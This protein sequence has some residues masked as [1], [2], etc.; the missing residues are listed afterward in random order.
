MAKM[1][2]GSLDSRDPSAGSQI[3]R[4]SKLPSHSPDI[5]IKHTINVDDPAH[6]LI[7]HKEER[8]RNFNTLVRRQVQDL[9]LMLLISLC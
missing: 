7:Q 9:D 4:R 6:I 3:P 8:R 1:R 5:I 2:G